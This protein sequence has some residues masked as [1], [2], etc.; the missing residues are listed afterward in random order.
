[1]SILWKA[2][3]YQLFEYFK[4]K[5]A[6]TTTHKALPAAPYWS[7]E[8]NDEGYLGIYNTIMRKSVEPFK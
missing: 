1:M 5:S 4:A 3:D 6:V 7:V 2:A 8:D